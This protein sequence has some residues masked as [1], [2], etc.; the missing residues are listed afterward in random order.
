[1]TARGGEAE[2]EAETVSGSI[3]L[4]F[5]RFLNLSVEPVSGGAE[6][7]G[8]LAADGEFSFELHSGTLE[9]TVPGDVSAEF[10]VATFSGGIDNGF[11]QKSRKTS[12]YTPGRELEFSNN[13]GEARVRID[14]FS[15]D[16]VINRK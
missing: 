10:R 14:T 7:S 3:V 16:V 11:G 4:E 12:K 8:D 9:L 6:V 15:G 5:E 2:V 1:M 13:G